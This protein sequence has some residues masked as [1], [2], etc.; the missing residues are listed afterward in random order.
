[1]HLVV[2]VVWCEEGKSQIYKKSKIWT[3]EKHTLRRTY[4]TQRISI[5]A[6]QRGNTD[7]II[8][9]SHRYLQKMNFNPYFFKNLFEQYNFKEKILL[10]LVVGNK[11]YKTIIK[12]P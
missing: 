11:R 1:M 9:I 7:C 12:I 3:V 5:I 10:C 2:V 8:S 6:I 4:P